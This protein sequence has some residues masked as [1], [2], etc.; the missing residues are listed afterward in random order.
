MAEP[1][2]AYVCET[3][4]AKCAER[5]DHVLAMLLICKACQAKRYAAGKARQRAAE[6]R[7]G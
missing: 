1:V 7:D 2:V 5:R 3:C 4:Q 6:A